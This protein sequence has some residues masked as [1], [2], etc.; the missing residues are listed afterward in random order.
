[1]HPANRHVAPQKRDK[2]LILKAGRMTKGSHPRPPPDSAPV[3]SHFASC[4]KT[5]RSISSK[6]ACIE[7]YLRSNAP[8]IFGIDL[9]SG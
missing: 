5:S 1:M 2:P 7:T 8:R 3:L 6:G 9:S 4:A